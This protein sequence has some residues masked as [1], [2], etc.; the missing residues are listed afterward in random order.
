[1]DFYY[2]LF[3]C[4]IV[5][6]DRINL[7]FGAYFGNGHGHFYFHKTINNFCNQVYGGKHLKQQRC[8]RSYLTRQ[9]IAVYSPDIHDIQY[10]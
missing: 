1:M 4:R 5:D 8:Q 7:G 9:S 10:K 6:M 3:K 2:F